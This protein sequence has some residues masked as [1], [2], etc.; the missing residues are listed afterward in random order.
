MAR[1]NEPLRHAR[2]AALAHDLHGI[3]R[4]DQ[5]DYTAQHPHDV[6]SR[7]REERE[8]AARPARDCVG[9][10]EPPRVVGVRRL[11][12][13]FAANAGDRIRVEAAE[14][15]CGFRRE[16]APAHDGLRPPLFQRSV[17]EIGV[18]SCRQHFQSQRRGRREVAGD[19]AGERGHAALRGAVVRLAR[20][21]EEARHRREVDDPAVALLPHDHGRRFDRC[22]VALQVH[23]DDV[24]PLLL[25]EVEDHPV[26]QDR[27]AVVLHVEPV[28]DV[29]AVA[30]LNEA[31]QSAIAARP[32]TSI[33]CLKQTV[34]RVRRQ[35]FSD[36]AALGHHQIAR[37][38]LQR[39][40]RQHRPHPLDSAIAH[41]AP[42]SYHPGRRPHGQ[43]ARRPPDSQHYCGLFPWSH[44]RPMRAV[45]P[46]ST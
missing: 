22:E 2:Q 20:V 40:A 27:R 8:Q 16:P 14:V 15:G 11:G 32:Q 41:P 30:R 26:A 7:F 12:P 44:H 35:A 38:Q 13:C 19:H 36:I 43:P 39:V 6:A 21:A 45:V 28:A 5:R 33:G 25:G 31:N 24:V 42:P 37:P 1:R 18:G 4:D 46:P 3:D 17:V 9:P 23:P 34:D 29:L 10:R